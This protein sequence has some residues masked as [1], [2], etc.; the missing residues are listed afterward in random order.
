MREKK[1]KIRRQPNG[2]HRFNWRPGLN[3]R[4]KVRLRSAQRILQERRREEKEKQ[5]LELSRV[6]LVLKIFSFSRTSK[7]S[8]IVESVRLGHTGK[9]GSKARNKWQIH[10]LAPLEGEVREKEA[11]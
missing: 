10:F 9:L 4:C 7:R 5:K 2:S 8:I 1:S 11:K 3:P 6:V